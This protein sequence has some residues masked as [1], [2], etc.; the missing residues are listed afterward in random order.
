MALHVSFPAN[1]YS[2]NV[3]RSRSFVVGS[4]LVLCLVSACAG[5][6]TTPTA[7]QC[8][9]GLR[10]ASAELDAAQ[11]KGFSGSVAFAKAAGLL[12]GAKVQQ[13]FGKYP[14]CINKVKRARYYLK[15]AKLGKD[16]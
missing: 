9:N 11:A 13:Q 10:V 8:D 12:T 2:V 3:I 7:Q 6:P 4:V 16:S 1:C 14:N 5:E 15:Q